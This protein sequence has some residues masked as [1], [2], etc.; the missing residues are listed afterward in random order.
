MNL[1]D[2]RHRLKTLVLHLGHVPSFSNTTETAVTE[3]D[4]TNPVPA[5]GVSQPEQPQSAR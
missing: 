1:G 5:E 2:V 3:P 4:H